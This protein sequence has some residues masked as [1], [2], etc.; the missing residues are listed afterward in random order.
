MKRGMFR[1]STASALTLLF[2]LVAQ[3]AHAFFDPPWITPAAPRAGEIVSVN[4]HGGVCD[5]ILERQGY[6]QVTRN[7]NAVRIIEFGDHATFQDFCIYGEGTVTEPI[8][9]FPPGDY[10]LTVDFAYSDPLYGPTISTLGV[11][12]FTVIGAPA[13]APVPMTGPLGLIAIL[14]LLPSLAIWILQ[15]RRRSQR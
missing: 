7:G 5:T 12:P 4:I 14:V 13:T 15:I 6:P 1:R 9:A 8:G 10:M 11:F 3:T 2:A